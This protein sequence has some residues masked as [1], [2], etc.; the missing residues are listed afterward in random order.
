MIRACID[1]QASEYI[2]KYKEENELVKAAKDMEKQLKQKVQDEV[3]RI[4]IEKK[5]E[6]LL[7]AENDDPLSQIKVE[8]VQANDK[9]VES[10]K[11]FKTTN[12][13]CDVMRAKSLRLDTNICVYWRL[14]CLSS[15]ILVQDVRIDNIAPVEDK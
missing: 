8:V 3:A 10:I 2:D 12:K 6:P 15:D 9:M 7:I 4:I 14:N 5:G 11:K 1:V 13:T